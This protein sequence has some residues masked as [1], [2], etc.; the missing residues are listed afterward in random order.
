[1]RRKALVY[2]LFAML[3]AS[4]IFVLL[5]Y[6]ADVS[7]DLDRLVAD[8]IRTDRA[9]YFFTGSLEDLG[10][11]SYISGKRALLGVTDRL[12]ADGSFT[13]TYADE[14]LEEAAMNGTSNG[15]VL[16]LMSGT[17]LKDWGSS[18]ESLGSSYA[19]DI[20]ARVLNATI[21]QSTPFALGLATSTFLAVRDSY[22]ELSFTR[23]HES[24]T[25]V[26]VD[27]AEDVFLT[28]NSYGALRR[29]VE[30]CNLSLYP[31][32]ASLLSSSASE[33]SYSSGSWVSGR[34]T[35]DINDSSPSGKI[36]VVDNIPDPEDVEDF[37]GVVSGNPS[38][39]NESLSNY[40]LGADVNSIR[41]V[42]DGRLLVMT[43]NEVWANNILD[44]LTDSC[45]F[46]EPDGPSFLDRL[47]GGYS[48][49]PRYRA[50]DGSS[51]G[52]S[53]FVDASRLPDPLQFYR[54]SLDFAYFDW[55][56]SPS[57]SRIKGVTEKREGISEKPWFRLDDAHVTAWG[58][59]GLAY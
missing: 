18:L 50:A 58:I 15:T 41:T 37:L 30:P 8:R 36:L 35:E 28:I 9:H 47:E 49:S 29:L 20:E 57:L 32:H 59:S 23:T 5:S 54:S 51:L 45:Y 25:G 43:S 44:E 31:Y 17:A 13:D 38:D 6:Q 2:T 48:P 21:N 24:I 4:S 39:S 11:S 1:M 16:G 10:R 33:Y 26:A 22:L 34:K 46:A 12:V 14:V 40:I 52:I 7:S 53:S 27:G 3:M 19:L 42:P 55:D 56:N